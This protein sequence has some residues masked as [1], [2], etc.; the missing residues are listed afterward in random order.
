MRGSALKR[1]ISLFVVASIGVLLVVVT[2]SQSPL[3]AGLLTMALASM[4][5]LESAAR[6]NPLE[7]QTTATVVTM[8]TRS[9]QPVERDAL[10]YDLAAFRAAQGPR[11]AEVTDGESAPVVRV[12]FR[13]DNTRRQLRAQA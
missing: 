7:S 2:A 1:N 13:R 5:W 11:T 6:R 8:P 3:W 10:V 4:A 9:S 12:D